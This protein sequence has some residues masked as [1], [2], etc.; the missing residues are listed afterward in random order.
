MTLVCCAGSAWALLRMGRGFVPGPV[1]S[2]VPSGEG[3]RKAA[4]VPVEVVEPPSFGASGA[5]PSRPVTEPS[6]PSELAPALAGALGSLGLASSAFAAF[7]MRGEQLTPQTFQPVCPAADNLYRVLQAIG[8]GV[9]ATE[10]GQEY[11]P[12]MIEV[13]LRVRLEIC[14]LESFVYEAIVPFIQ[15]KGLSWILP[16]HE[17]LD[18]VI[19]G[20]VFALSLNFLLFGATKILAV[21]SIYHD[22]LLG[23]PLRFIGF[24]VYPEAAKEEPLPFISI[25]WPGKDGPQTASQQKKMAEE[26]ASKEPPNIGL[27]AV[28]GFSK[29]YGIFSGFLRD[30]FEGLDTFTG[31]YLVIVSITYVAFKIAHFKLFN[32]FPPF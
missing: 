9:V 7:P 2:S 13:F 20:V 32:D 14:V 28:G 12:L 30:F 15:R 31:R 26:I 29:G 5:L 6:A 18:T 24:A 25:N 23:T 8:D 17:T 16:L 22:F 21:L 4:A 19:A 3:V 1:C 11:R 27:A 10:A